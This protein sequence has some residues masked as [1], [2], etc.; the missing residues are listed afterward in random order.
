MMLFGLIERKDREMIQLSSGGVKFTIIIKTG[1]LDPTEIE[2]LMQIKDVI[3]VRFDD[4]IGYYRVI[5]E[6]ST[7]KELTEGRYKR[8]KKDIR[9]ILKLK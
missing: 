2:N 5:F 3:Y 6:L 8:A 9:A 7:R 1:Y 4:T